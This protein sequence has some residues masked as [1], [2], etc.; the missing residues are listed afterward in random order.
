MRVPVPSPPP[1][2]MV[3][4]AMCWS[5]RCSSCTALVVRM[6]PVPPSGWPRR[7]GAAVGV[8]ALEV[9]VELALP[10]QHDRGEGLVDL[11]DVDVGHGHAVAVEQALGGVDR[12]GEHE[13]RVDAD[14]AG[15]DDAGQ[16][17]EAEGVGLLAGHHQ[18]GAGAVGD[19]RR[20]AGGVHAV[21]AGDGLEV[22]QRLEGGVAQA[23]VALDAVGGAGGLA[24][25]VEVGRVDRRRSG[26]R[27]DPRP[28]PAAPSSCE[29]RPN[30]SASARVMPH[31]SA[32][33]SAPSN[34][35]VNSYWPK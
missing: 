23:L 27:S 2:H 16:R 3:T 30:S 5:A 34:W 28:R 32:M 35:V 4:S 12:A 13:H 25:V 11:D 14:E 26:C 9:D 33:R 29:R 7:D 20:V 10:G 18:H 31:L 19:L 8:D 1:Q 6:A 22:G 17:R 21:F 15:V 24:V